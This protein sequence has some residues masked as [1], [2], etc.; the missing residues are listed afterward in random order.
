MSEKKS[1]VSAVQDGRIEIEMTDLRRHNVINPVMEI[2][3]GSHL[4]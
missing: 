1:P 2:L 4:N 3:D